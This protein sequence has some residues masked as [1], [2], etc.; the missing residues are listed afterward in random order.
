MRTDTTNRPA[1]HE[2][3]EAKNVAWTLL[4]RRQSTDSNMTIAVQRF[5]P[6][7]TFAEHVHDLE[8]FFYVTQG[9]MEMTV[10]GSTKTYSQGD[11]VVVD[12]NEPHSG[13][14]VSEGA[15]EL[16]FVD[17]WPSDSEDRLGLD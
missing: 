11:F 17:Y 12:R 5:E 13:R 7:G 8:Q 10:G 2:A 3:T 6:G 4:S 16:L 14:N 9:Q 1:D 15:S